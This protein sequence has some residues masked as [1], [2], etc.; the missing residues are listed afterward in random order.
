M[1]H[2]PDPAAEAD[3]LRGLIRDAHAA[4]KDLRAA[5]RDTGQLRAQL[6][7]RFEAAAND[8]IAELAN[9]LQT[10]ANGYSAGLNANVEAAREEI[11]RHL[12]DARIRYDE[13]ADNFVVV[14][15]GAKFIEDTPAPYPERM[16]PP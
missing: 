6:T 15:Q 3:Q 16:A 5:I 10:I 4:V 12:F 1:G 14:F 8:A 11:A 7:D 9:H 13:T 2:N